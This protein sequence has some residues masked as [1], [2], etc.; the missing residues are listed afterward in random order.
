MTELLKSQASIKGRAKKER[1]SNLSE[2]LNMFEEN[3]PLDKQ[4]QEVY[5]EIKTELNTILQE[6]AKGAIFR[7][8]VQWH[9]HGEHNS[10]Y[11]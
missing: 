4:S 6:K 7:S 5:E 1:I 8:K 3:F 10:Q 9:E 2:K 11:F